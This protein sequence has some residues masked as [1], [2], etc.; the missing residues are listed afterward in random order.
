M[1]Q[2]ELAGRRRFSLKRWRPLA[3]RGGREPP[4]A[5]AA[6]HSDEQLMALVGRDDT[7][8]LG[9]L[10][11]RHHATLFAFLLRL[12][13]DR[14]VAE[15]LAQEVFWRLWEQRARFDPDRSF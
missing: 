7:A 12:A 1:V 2:A 9:E 3:P 11:D 8:A 15:D 13:A 6:A 4:P 5:Q 10:F 14:A